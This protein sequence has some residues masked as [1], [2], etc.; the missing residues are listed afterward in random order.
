M[1]F[2]IQ[3]NIFLDPDHYKVFE[4]L[5]ELKI[6]YDTINILPNATEIEYETSRKDVFVYG[7][8]TIGN[9]VLFMVGIICMRHILNFTEK[10]F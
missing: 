6:E 4:A 3:K 2:L 1:F 10:I 9:Q 5:D 8:V 7:S